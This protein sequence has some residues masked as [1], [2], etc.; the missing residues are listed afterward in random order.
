MS[1][2][3]AMR[4]VRSSMALSSGKNLEETRTGLLRVPPVPARFREHVGTPRL[5]VDG[6]E[7]R[8]TLPLSG[9]WQGLPLRSV[10]LIAWVESESGFALVFDATA[11]Q[12]LEAA[13]RAGL[14]IP[15]SG[16]EY[17]DG[18]VLGVN[19]GVERHGRGAA[20]FRVAG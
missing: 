10:V 15:A 19:V 16:S 11:E 17:R 9:T 2:T 5:A 8:A 3:P 13:N 4:S 14:R 6:N 20:L 1:A 7:Y 18:E 12:L